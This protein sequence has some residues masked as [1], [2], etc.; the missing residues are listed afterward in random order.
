MMAS[1]HQLQSA[2]LSVVDEI[3]R[4]LDSPTNDTQGISPKALR[5]LR[6][7]HAALAMAKS[8]GAPRWRGCYV[9]LQGRF[10]LLYRAGEY[11]GAATPRNLWSNIR[12]VSQGKIAALRLEDHIPRD[13]LPGTRSDDLEQIASFIAVHG[14]TKPKAQE[15]REEAQ[16][17]RAQAQTI[18]LADLGL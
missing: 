1:L 18:T 3:V 13:L 8:P 17:Q 6:R 12:A 14:V 7:A 15:R 11:V 2:V 10:A 4:E 5:K 9:E 16:A